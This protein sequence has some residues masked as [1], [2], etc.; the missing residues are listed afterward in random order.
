MKR[1]ENLILKRRNLVVVLLVFGLVISSMLTA[2]GTSTATTTPDTKQEIVAVDKEEVAQAEVGETKQ[3]VAVQETTEEVVQSTEKV[4]GPQ[5]LGEWVKSVDATEPKL[6][7]WNDTTKEGMVLENGQ[8]YALKKE[9][10]L[11]FCHEGEKSNITCWTPIMSRSYGTSNY[12]VYEFNDEFLEETLFK[13]TIIIEDVEYEASVVLVS[14]NATATAA[15]VS[16]STEVSGKDW[17]NSL[18]YEEPKLVA[19]NDATG[20][21][22]VIEQGGKYVM[23]Q[24]DVLGVYHPTE[25]YVFTVSPV[26][27][28]GGLTDFPKVTVMEYQLPS[29]SQDINLEVEV[30]KG[31]DEFITFNYVVTTP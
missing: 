5:S 14:E 20:T 29:E 31:N 24:G 3:D 2:C 30:M 13:L 8:K 21:K 26:D 10:Q 4:V 15:E 6:T 22:E 9:E 28:A 16:E 17:A 23:K 1:K 27:F 7:I 11:V 25:Y 19:W 18:E 12:S